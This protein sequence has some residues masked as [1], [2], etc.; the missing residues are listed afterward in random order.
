MFQTFLVVA[1]C[2]FRAQHKPIALN[3]EIFV[4]WNKHYCGSSIAIFAKISMKNHSTKNLKIYLS[5]RSMNLDLFEFLLCLIFAQIHRVSTKTLVI[6]GGGSSKTISTER[7]K[8]E[9]MNIISF[10]GRAIGDD[11]VSGRP[12]PQRP[13]I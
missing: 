5:L 11:P 13:V 6:Q 4:F 10:P 9:G 3:L 2:S 1:S 12:G 7:D 8:L